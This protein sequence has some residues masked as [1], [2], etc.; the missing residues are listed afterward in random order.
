VL[1]RSKYAFSIEALHKQSF[2]VG[3]KQ[4]GGWG[5]VFND[6]EEVEEF[7][8]EHE[9]SK[10]KQDMK[11]VEF[12]TD[13]E[14]LRLKQIYSENVNIV[15][16]K[17]IKLTNKSEGAEQHLYFNPIKYISLIKNTVLPEW[18]AEFRPAAAKKPTAPPKDLNT[19]L[20]VHDTTFRKYLEV[21]RSVEVGYDTKLYEVSDT[22]DK[23]GKTKKRVHIEVQP[24]VKNSLAMMS[25][26]NVIF[27]YNLTEEQKSEFK[28]FEEQLASNTKDDEIVYERVEKLMQTFF[29]KEG[30]CTA[31]FETDFE[32]DKIFFVKTTINQNDPGYSAFERTNI[33]YLG[34]IYGSLKEGA[35]NATRFL[36]KH[37]KVSTILGSTAAGA[38]I[39]AGIAMILGPGGVLVGAA[40]G[41]G[42]GTLAA[43]YQA[44]ATV[45]PA[46]KEGLAA[47]EALRGIENRLQQHLAE[48]QITPMAYLFSRME[49][50]GA[51]DLSDF[52]DKKSLNITMNMMGLSSRA[53]EPQVLNGL[54]YSGVA[55]PLSY[56]LGS[57]FMIPHATF[58]FIYQN[59]KW[60]RLPVH[61]ALS[62]IFSNKTLALS[63]LK[64]S[65]KTTDI[66]NDIV[67][68]AKENMGY[69]N[70]SSKI[71][72]MYF[73]ET[74]QTGAVDISKY[75]NPHNVER[76]KLINFNINPNLIIPSMK[77]FPS[78]YNK[79][80][81]N[82]L[83]EYEV[84]RENFLESRKWNDKSLTAPKTKGWFW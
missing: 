75:D 17:R 13:I 78:T 51:V 59:E 36:A 22:T 15:F 3:G 7:N 57:I 48:Q 76:E 55:T 66:L 83:K 54:K 25:I 18:R 72:S 26:L 49:L 42:F 64:K 65:T 46:T 1:V 16:S 58:D 11:S 14:S 44:V 4:R 33:L 39:G 28:R 6:E 60:K 8:A 77:D 74:E 9:P 56:T 70:D 38:G 2:Q 5:S 19:I 41:L 50:I 37:P 68:F 61:A 35:K 12:I 32:Q 10:E 21:Y 62:A 63:Y 84:D 53:F 31:F 29:T 24:N 82:L 40:A 20:S 67:S 52:N 71:E 79:P 23:T 45:D 43:L 47:E 34:F 73:S 81:G 30:V 27:M 80:L 69:M